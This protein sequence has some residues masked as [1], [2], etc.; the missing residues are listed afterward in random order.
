[1]KKLEK[2]EIY[3]PEDIKNN[4]EKIVRNNAFIRKDGLFYLASGYT[5]SEPSKRLESSARIIGKEYFGDNFIE[6]YLRKYPNTF[7]RP[8]YHSNEDVI[9]LAKL[10]NIPPQIVED[11]I[12][13]NTLG[14]KKLR[15][16][17]DFNKIR[18]IL[19]HFYGMALFARIE[20]VGKPIE[21]IKYFDHS[22]LPNPEWYGAKPTEE[23]LTTMK[24]LM[25]LNNEDGIESPDVYIKKMTLHYDDSIW[26]S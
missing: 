24:L 21:N 23:Q 3:G 1:M 10:L 7:S 18:S 9:Y 11:N 22:I 15:K 16:D 26:H 19:I 6:K 14:I 12:A 20:Q 2:L 17:N 25:N 4:K 5:G 13:Q 8:N